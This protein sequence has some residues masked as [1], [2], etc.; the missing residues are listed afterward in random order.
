MYLHNKYTTWY[1]SI[2]QRA[3]LRS[4][5]GYK[6]RHHIIP[7]SLGGSNLKENLVDLT[8]REHFICHW[9]LTKMVVGPNKEKM[10][11]AAWTMA[12]LEN[13]SQQRYKLTGRVYESLKQEYSKIKSVRLKTHN[14]MNNPEVRKR[15]QEA[16]NKRG[17]TLGNTG[18]KRGPIS[19]KL[20][21]VLRQRTIEQMT[22]ERKE[23]IRQQQLNRTLEQKEKY[24]FVHSKR[25]SCIHCRR[26]CN[27][28]SFARYHGSNCKISK[29]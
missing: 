16:I 4:L 12:N 21:D 15:H 19:D 17:K 10:I 6:E 29:Q 3:K 1:N 11:Y 13:K 8:A 22:P 28:G 18:H 7:K 5:I 24:A 20:R 26:L 23:Q 14:P 2:I 25:I 27:P 9:L